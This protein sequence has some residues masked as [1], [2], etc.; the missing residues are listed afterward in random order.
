MQSTYL[1]SS[2]RSFVYIS[3]II[4]YYDGNILTM[5]RLK[6]GD[7][8]ERLDAIT[9]S[10]LSV[11]DFSLIYFMHSI[12]DCLEYSRVQSHARYTFPRR[13]TDTSIHLHGTAFIS[14][15]PI[16]CSMQRGR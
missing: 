14:R 16:N 11:T 2:Q 13:D 4:S 5:L 9:A 1:K 10:I 3:K 15:S 7:L 8:F 6:R 12:V